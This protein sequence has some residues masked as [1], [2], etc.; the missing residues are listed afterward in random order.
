MIADP[1][2]IA[3]AKKHR[4]IIVALDDKAIM[5]L[6]NKAYSAPKAVYDKAAYYAA[7]MN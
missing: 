5:D 3:D 1:E 7:Q 6:L 4:A 2:F